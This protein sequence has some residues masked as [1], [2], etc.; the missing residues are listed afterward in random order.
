MH[1]PQPPQ[2]TVRAVATAVCRYHTRGVTP[3]TWADTPVPDNH[4][5]L[6]LRDHRTGLRVAL[7]V[8]REAHLW[9]AAPVGPAA[10]AAYLLMETGN[11]VDDVRRFL[12]PGVTDTEPP[13]DVD[14]EDPRLSLRRVMLLHATHTQPHPE[15]ET[16][17]YILKAW[18]LWVSGAV[19]RQVTWRPDDGMPRI[20]RWSVDVP[21]TPP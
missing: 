21:V 12:A 11:T 9:M 10:T 20:A 14:Y 3:Y 5:N 2:A 15:H 18:H 4:V 13:G 1:P 16:L 19:A 8:G 7:A 6:L 17:A